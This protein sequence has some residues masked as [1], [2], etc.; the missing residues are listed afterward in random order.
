MALE[1]DILEIPIL[2]L[3]D[4]LGLDRIDNLVDII[5]VWRVATA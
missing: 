2:H 3:L 1:L 5:R 4:N